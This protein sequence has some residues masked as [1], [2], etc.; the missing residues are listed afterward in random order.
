MLDNP[1]RLAA[2]YQVGRAAGTTERRLNPH[3]GGAKRAKKILDIAA[4]FVV[5]LILE[6]SF[7]EQPACRV[8]R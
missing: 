3:A 5:D 6:T 2:M 4:F 1:Q 7:C 8:S